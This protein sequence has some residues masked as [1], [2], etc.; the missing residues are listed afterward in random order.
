MQID[1]FLAAEQSFDG[2]E[3]IVL[4]AG[5]N[6]LFFA[7]NGLGTIANNFED[8]ITELAAAGGRYFL[9]ATVD[10]DRAP[11]VVGTSDE[12]RYREQVVS[13]NQ[14]LEKRLKK[15]AE[16]LGVTVVM[17]D[18]YAVTKAVYADPASYGFANMN[19]IE[20]FLTGAGGVGDPDDFFWWDD[21]HL[22]R[23]IHRIVGEA[24]AEFV[25]EV[26]AAP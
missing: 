10:T 23:V 12:N 2:D 22:T 24:A 1:F 11:S 9:V 13:L 25:S 20:G 26:F 18:Y 4:G 6:D 19:V 17:F 14:L 21:F 16:K 8:H 15:L 5:F 3:L 7:P